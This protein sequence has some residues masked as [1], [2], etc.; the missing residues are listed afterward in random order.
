M[1]KWKINP[2]NCPP[3]EAVGF[4]AQG[5]QDGEASSLD[6]P[7]AACRMRWL[8]NAPSKALA[9]R[10]EERPCPAQD[11]IWVKSRDFLSTV[12]LVKGLGGRTGVWVNRSSWGEGCGSG[13][14]GEDQMMCLVFLQQLWCCILS[15]TGSEGF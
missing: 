7:V 1:R 13:C 9:G 6:R 15:W 14:C 12:L 8:A 2:V 10:S 11:L 5:W 4:R 3:N